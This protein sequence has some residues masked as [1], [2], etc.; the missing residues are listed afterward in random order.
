MQMSYQNPHASGPLIIPVLVMCNTPDEEIE[1]NIR[2]NAARDLPW[3]AMR[4]A[5]DQ[6]AVMV[7]GGPSAE[8]FIERI[9]SFR[10][11]G[12]TVFAMNA[13]SQWLRGHWINADFQVVGDAKEETATLVDTLAKAHLFASQVNPKTMEVVER[14]IVWHLAIDDK[15][16]RFFP[17]ERVAR[18]GYALI[19]GGSAVGNIAMCIAYTLGYRTF[20]VFGYDSSHREGRSHAYEQPMNQFMQCVDVEWGGR[21]YYCSIAMRAQAETFQFTARSLIKEGCTLNV[22]GDGL[23]PAMW[24]TPPQ[25]LT[26]KDKYRLMWQF[27]GYRTAAP[28]EGLWKHFV[29]LVRPDDT[30]IDFGCGTGRASMALAQAGHRVMLVDFADN[31]RDDEAMSLPFLEWDL[32]VP[33]PLRAK[34]G[35]CTDVMEHI[36]PEQVDTVLTNIMASAKKTFFQISTVDDV[37]G[38]LIGAPL[39]L[40]VHPHDWWKEKLSWHGTVTWDAAGENASLFIVSKEAA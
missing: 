24:N 4:P 20:H 11:A 10:D 36:P 22:H 30:I 12:A 18:G 7:G 26:E 21:T 40:S 14:P 1:R 32:S 28:G 29:E 15:M 17:T 37:C 3:V 33:C 25:N 23:L 38:A 8:D 27:D 5:H 34:Y 35:L 13:A 2:I 19:G 39:H 9:R 31:C 16:E 6:V